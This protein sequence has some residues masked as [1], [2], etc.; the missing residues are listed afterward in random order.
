MVPATCVPWPLVLQSW[1]FQPSPIA[2][3][4]T[5]A[6]PSNSVCAVRTPVSITYTVTL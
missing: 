3:N 1:P 2:S 4:A 5:L 6:R